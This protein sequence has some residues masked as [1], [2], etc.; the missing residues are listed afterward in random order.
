MLQPEHRPLLVGGQGAAV[1]EDRIDGI[2]LRS[3]GVTEQKLG[4]VA[5][6]RGIRGVWQPELL[7][8]CLPPA[9]YASGPFVAKP[10]VQQVSLRQIQSICG[11]GYA[12]FLGHKARAESVQAAVDAGG[13]GYP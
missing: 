9:Q 13:D 11:G 4:Q 6:H 1:E 3:A 12:A 7:Q 10:V 8:P 2:T 5:R